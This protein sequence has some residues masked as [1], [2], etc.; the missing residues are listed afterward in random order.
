LVAAG[1]ID[2]GS[3]RL[4]IDGQEVRT[5]KAVTG[6]GP[7][8]RV[9]LAVR[10]EGISLGHGPDGANQLHGTIEDINFLGSIVRL[11]LRL[12]DGAAGDAATTIALDTFNEPHLSLPAVGETVTVSFPPEACFVLGSAR[13]GAVVAAEVGAEV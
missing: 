3:G 10:P 9:T 7:G 6:A 1:V 4:S 13:D 11:R 8:G 2:A 5:P 12:G